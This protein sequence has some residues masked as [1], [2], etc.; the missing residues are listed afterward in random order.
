MYRVCLDAEKAIQPCVDRYAVGNNGNGTRR[1]VRLLIG[2]CGLAS[3]KPDAGR[4]VT[5]PTARLITILYE[6]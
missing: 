5:H 4:A 6:F 2:K 3:L 1:P